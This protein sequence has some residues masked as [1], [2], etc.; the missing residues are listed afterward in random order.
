MVEKKV[1]AKV[2]KKE[3]KNVLPKKDAEN[4]DASGLV[5][6]RLSTFV[7]QKLLNGEKI[8]IYNAEKVIIT[9]DPKVIVEDY[10]KRFTYRNKGNPE[11]SPKY[12]RLPHLILKNAIVRMLP[13]G[14]RG[15]AAAKKLMVYIGNDENK[16]CKTVGVAKIKQG[17]KYIE[18]SDLSKRIGAKW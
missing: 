3:T 2:V 7:A 16:T 6:G 13:T 5:L 18:L 17:L 4:Y 15:V 14:S 10:S 9:G 1:S 12:P 11:Y 8:N